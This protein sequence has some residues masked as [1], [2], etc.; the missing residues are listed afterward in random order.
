MRQSLQYA[1][2]IVRLLLI[3]YRMC[4][5]YKSTFRTNTQRVY[6]ILIAVFHSLPRSQLLTHWT[7]RT[8]WAIGLTEPMVLH[9]V[10]WILLSS[11]QTIIA[12]VIHTSLHLASRTP[13][14]SIPNVMALIAVVM[15]DRSVAHW[16]A[17]KRVIVFQVLVMRTL[18]VFGLLIT[19]TAKE[20]HACRTLHHLLLGDRRKTVDEGTA[21]RKRTNTA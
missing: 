7:I 18:T 13:S 10:H 16:A 1:N 4:F 6:V 3:Q 21:A 15:S 2:L 14:C 12:P 20:S 9:A 17:T 8:Y 19:M 11:I 5:L